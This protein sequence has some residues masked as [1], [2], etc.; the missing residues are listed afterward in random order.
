MEKQKGQ[1]KK[2]PHAAQAHHLKGR[3]R[4]NCSCMSTRIFG[5]GHCG[6]QASINH[7]GLATQIWSVSG[8]HYNESSIGCGQPPL[9]YRRGRM[10][11]EC[12][13]WTVA[14]SDPL[15]I[16]EQNNG[17]W[18]VLWR[19][20]GTDSV[21]EVILVSLFHSESEKETHIFCHLFCVGKF[22]FG[23]ST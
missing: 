12:P 23:L 1:R 20:V 13:E 4:A 3:I 9:S 17:Q 2:E 15:F 11:S 19:V 14:S 8:D 18:S 10:R 7:G 21:V 6:G 16:G 22:F 5:T